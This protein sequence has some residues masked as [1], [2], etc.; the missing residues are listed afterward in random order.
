MNKIVLFLFLV[1]LIGCKRTPSETSTKLSFYYW[2]TQYNLDSIERNTLN[3]LAIDKLYIRYF[4]VGLKQGQ[5]VPITPIVFKE[6]VDSLNIVSVIY[7]KNEVMLKKDLNV[8]E[9]AAR[10]DQFIKQINE[11][12]QIE[13]NEI[14]IDCDWSLQSKE[15]F[16]K[17]IDELTYISQSKISSTI[18]LHQIKYAHKTGIPKVDHGALMYYNMGGISSDTLNSIYDR[19]TANKYLGNFED[20]PLPLNYA[21]PIYSWAVISRNQKVIK[22]ISRVRVSDVV[23]N[24]ILLQSGPN[25]FVVQENTELFGQLLLKGDEV[26][27]ETTTSKQLLEMKEDLKKAGAKAPQEIILYD[28]NTRNI[29]AYEKETFKALGSHW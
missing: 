24:S 27:F 3:E 1:L 11:K 7:I 21:L 20:Y 6:S 4:D 19:T 8:K 28:L 26:K 29:T 9:L 13:S 18:R 2:R 15:R 25:I 23:E 14:Q 10:I 22:L 17:F 16:F 5:A 12:N